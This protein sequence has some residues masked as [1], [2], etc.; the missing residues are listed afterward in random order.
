MLRMR[1]GSV[2]VPFARSAPLRSRPP[3]AARTP[4][5]DPSPDR[6]PPRSP[7]RTDRLVAGR[8]AAGRRALAWA[9][10]GA[11]ASWRPDLGGRSSRPTARGSAGKAAA[12]T[13]TPTGTPSKG[14]RPSPGATAWPTP[15]ERPDPDG[16][17]F[18]GGLIGHLGYDLAPRLERLPRRGPAD[19]RLP[20]LRFGLYDTFVL[21]DHRRGSS[22]LW[23][24]DLLDDG[25]VDLAR[26]W[27]RWRADL[28]EPP[29]TAGHRPH[30]RPLGPSAI[31]TTT[32]R[33]SAGPSTTSRPATSTR[34]TSRT[35]SS[36]EGRVDPLELYLKLKAIS[37]APFASFLA[38]DDLAIVGAS[39]ELFY[40]TDGDR[41][42]TRPI[43][44]TRPRSPDPVEDARLA[45]ELAAS[46]KDRAEL[47]M[48]VDLERN[49]LGRVCRFGTVRVVDPGA[50]ESFEQVHHLVA[51]IEGRLRAGVGPVDVVRAVFPGGSITGAPKIRAME[52]I[53]ELEPNR[54]GVYT[55][56]VGY[57]SLGG[58]AAFNIAI[59]TMLVEGD[60]VTYQ[61]GGGIVAD[62]DPE[63]EYAETLA[64][65]P[66]D[67]AGAIEECRGEPMIWVDGQIVPDDGLTIR[68]S[69]GPS[70]MAS[71]SSR[72]SGPGAGR[73]RCSMRHKARM[74]RSAEELRIPIDPASLPD[75]RPSGAL[76]KPRGS[77]ATGSLRI[78]ATG[79]SQLGTRWS[80]CGRPLAIEARTPMPR[81]PPGRAWRLDDQPRRPA[82]PAQDAQLLV[83][84]DRRRGGRRSR[85]STRPCPDQDRASTAR[86]AD[87]TSSS[88]AGDRTADPVA[89]GPDPPGDHAR[90]GPRARQ[91]D[92][93]AREGGC[94]HPRAATPGRPTRSS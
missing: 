73:P 18:L 85:L 62:S 16:P 27:D 88:S 26:R 89:R 61:V 7:D 53:D 58:L 87:R 37:P 48:I 12:S 64:Q 29:P 68:S 93:M 70:S 76:S 44:G 57:F 52:I 69:T 2:A 24:V 50:V 41:I 51:T 10:P 91:G 22:E 33:P 36:P 13:S 11:G 3:R 83:P 30:S 21:V 47:T 59:R 8:R 6:H 90:A 14:W 86:E 28:D 31:A 54:R 49:D 63:A 81:D 34:P 67:A 40:R 43:K 5:G 72:P 17:P 75:A 20:A 55:G 74:L 56:A 1:P 42:V 45:A 82:R 71:A 9:R 79:G 38:W 77:T 84:A 78:T 4:P 46:A 23:A 80:G 25:P 65:G 92:R 32:S 19:S 66:R 94:R 35:A 39:P 15:R 60:R